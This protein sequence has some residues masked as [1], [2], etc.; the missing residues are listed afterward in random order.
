VERRGAETSLKLTSRR[1]PSER[2]GGRSGKVVIY[3]RGEKR[4]F[5]NSRERYGGKASRVTIT[6]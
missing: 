3:K 5:S 1:W 6:S 4:E 2:V